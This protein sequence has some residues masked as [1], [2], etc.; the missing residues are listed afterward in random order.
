MVLLLQ[1]HSLM[2][3][4]HCWHGVRHH[5]AVLW[6]HL[7]GVSDCIGVGVGRHH[8]GRLQALVTVQPGRV[9]AAAAVL[10]DCTEAERPTD[11]IH[12]NMHFSVTS[13]QLAKFSPSGSFLL[14]AVAVLD[15]LLLLEPRL[16]IPL[17][18]DMVSSSPPTCREFLYEMRGS[19]QSSRCRAI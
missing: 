19:Q 4:L 9:A 14:F 2:R 11:E 16:L 10:F 8:H 7:L 12:S 1:R 17:M 15:F 13:T 6:P 18:T 3:M 5:V